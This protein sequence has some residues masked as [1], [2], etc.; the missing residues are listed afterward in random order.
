M[1]KHKIIHGLS[2]V[3]AFALIVGIARGQA[4]EVTGAGSTFAYPLLAK[5]AEG[6]RDKTGVT[7]SYQAI[8]SGAGLKQIQGRAVD[9]GASDMPLKPADLDKSELLQFPLMVGGVVPVVNLAGIEA[10]RLKLTGEVLAQIYLGKI[11]KWNDP[12]IARLNPGL[13][14]G[15][16]AIAVIHR[17]DASGTTFIF[18]DYLSKVNPEWEASIGADTTVDWPIGVGG[19][20]NEGVSAYTARIAGS[21][22][23]VEYAY[24]KKNKLSYALMANHEGRF[25][26]PDI[27]AF[28]AAAANADW[29]RAS[30]FY[31]LLTDQ[32]GSGSWPMTGATFALLHRRAT[33]PNASKAALEFFDWALRS[34]SQMAEELDYVPIPGGVVS[35]IERA[36]ENIKT[37]DGKPV[38][39]APHM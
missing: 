8:G 15:D 34:G 36:W 16:L 3:L 9:F 35:R 32:P 37:A 11:T 23:Y 38:W 24:A 18:A 19:Q 30:G 1:T 20:G 17:S 13:A 2:A 28:Q 4:A 22:G 26:A 6:Y 21:I 33:Q 25:V 7:I 10:G 29:S 14:L 39:S 12:A 31:L 27:A 5:W